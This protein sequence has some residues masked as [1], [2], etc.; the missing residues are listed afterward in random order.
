MDK[1]QFSLIKSYVILCTGF[2][3]SEAGLLVAVSAALD[4]IG[5]LGFGYLSDLEIFDRKKAYAI[6]LVMC[7]LA[8]SV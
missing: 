2:T 3:K 7:Y 6:W 4:L 1:S 5:R 8:S